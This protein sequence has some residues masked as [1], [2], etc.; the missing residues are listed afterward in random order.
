MDSHQH[1]I[2]TS[3]SDCSQ[4]LR[5][6]RFMHMLLLSL[7]LTPCMHVAADFSQ[8]TPYFQNFVA[9]LA[10]MQQN[11]IIF[12]LGISVE[13]APKHAKRVEQQPYVWSC[14]S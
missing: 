14:G 3:V 2:G 12:I 8:T 5:A 13:N 11:I 9:K 6:K 4:G 10:E 1:Q 7:L